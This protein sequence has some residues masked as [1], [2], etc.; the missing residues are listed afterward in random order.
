MIRNVPDFLR[1]AVIVGLSVC[2]VALAADA[3]AQRRGGGARPRPNVSRQGPA[4]NGSFHSTRHHGGERRDDRPA[5]ERSARA[6]ASARREARPERMDA[7]R[8]N[9][10]GR[11]RGREMD[12]RRDDRYE[13]RPIPPADRVE[14]RRDDRRDYYDD[15]RDYY[16]DRRDFARG[17]RYSTVWWTSN[18]CPQTAT[19]MLDGYTYY[20]CDDAW[21]G[22]TYYG[23]EVTYTVIDAPEGY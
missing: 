3:W 13:D 6:D 16:D 1:L 18:S 7:R 2:L 22:R 19:V 5:A 17:A 14:E 10:G 23:G 8:V 4:A 20:Q 9:E 21:F 15:R 11:G 12:D